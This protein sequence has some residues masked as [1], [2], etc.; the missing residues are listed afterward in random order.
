VFRP[1]AKN[2]K[3]H[4]LHLQVREETQE[5]QATCSHEEISKARGGLDIEKRNTRGGNFQ[6]MIKQ[7]QKHKACTCK[8][9]KT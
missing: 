9:K 8:R 5:L 6:T 2:T 3:A 1:Q 4:G 7:T